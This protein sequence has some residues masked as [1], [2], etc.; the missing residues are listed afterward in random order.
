MRAGGAHVKPQ[1]EPAG[2]RRSAQ[3]RHRADF[4]RQ[5]FEQRV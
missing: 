4:G 5:P 2:A 3:R 1:R